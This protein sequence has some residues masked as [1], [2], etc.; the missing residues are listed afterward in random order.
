MA[1]K[2]KHSPMYFTLFLMPTDIKK[3]I[4]DKGKEPNYF[5]QD[6]EMI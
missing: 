6:I 3:I 1:L 2:L 4:G 5:S